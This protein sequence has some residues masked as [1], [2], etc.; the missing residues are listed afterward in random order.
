M[1]AYSWTCTGIILI[2]IFMILYYYS[3]YPPFRM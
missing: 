3:R 2:F 1:S